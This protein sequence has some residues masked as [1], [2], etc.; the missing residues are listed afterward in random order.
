MQWILEQVKEELS[1]LARR[2]FQLHAMD[3]WKLLAYLQLLAEQ[4]DLST[5]CNGFP[6]CLCTWRGLRWD[7]FNSMQWIRGGSE[8]IGKTNHSISFNSMQWIRWR[9]WGFEEAGRCVA[10][11]SMQWIRVSTSTGTFVTGV[12]ADFQLHAMDSV[13]LRWISI[14]T[15]PI[16]LSTPCNGFSDKPCSSSLATLSRLST[17]CNGFI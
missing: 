7:T 4:L 16:S 3:S 13:W 11:N 17:P 12:S 8:G 15:H 6:L 9:D 1:K 10:F 5:P 2:N 14:Q